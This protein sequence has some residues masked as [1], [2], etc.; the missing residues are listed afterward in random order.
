MLLGF[1]S[2]SA[3]PFSTTGSDNSVIIS[4]NPNNLVLTIGPVNISATSI[5]Q[6]VSPDPLVLG[7]GTVVIASYA[8]FTLTGSPLTLGTATVTAF[9][10]VAVNVTK[11]PLTL[12]NGTVIVTASANVIPDGVAMDLK[13]KEPGIITWNDIDPNADNVWIEIKPY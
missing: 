9:T 11:N 4:V 12:G 8:N 1:D 7:T 2:F 6:I 10:D 13:T 5:T 3:T